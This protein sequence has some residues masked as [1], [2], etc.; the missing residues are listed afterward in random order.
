MRTLSFLFSTMSACVLPASTPAKC[1]PNTSPHQPLYC[2][3]TVTVTESLYSNRAVTKTPVKNLEDNEES[4]TGVLCLK[5]VLSWA[6][7]KKSYLNR[8][9]KKARR[10]IWE[11]WEHCMEDLQ[12]GGYSRHVRNNTMTERQKH[13]RLIRGL[14]RRL[15]ASRLVLEGFFKT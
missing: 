2:I 6:V 3:R 10:H 5:W 8:D 4:Q 11:P 12:W 1:F 15:P 9:L 14:L 13:Y 7:L